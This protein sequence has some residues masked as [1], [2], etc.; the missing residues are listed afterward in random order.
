MPNTIDPELNARAVRLVLDHRNEYP[1][2]TAV[3]E[4]VVRQVLW[5][6]SPC[7]LGCAGRR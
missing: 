1:T 3:G 2:T 5:A 7:A 6:R 4:A